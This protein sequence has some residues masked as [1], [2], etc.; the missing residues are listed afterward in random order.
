MAKAMSWSTKA[1]VIF[2]EGQRGYSAYLIERGEVE[3]SIRRNGQ[4][5]KLASR[6][7]GEV[8]GEMA[9]I[10]DQP[11]SATVTA[12][13]PLPAPDDHPGPAGQPHRTDRSGAAHVPSG[14]PAALQIDPPA[15]AGH[16][17]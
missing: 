16:G 1:A 2:R 8:F 11:R 14:D 5:V 10:D 9:I 13:R 7:P 3:I 4:D 12:I 17:S 15:P 6:G